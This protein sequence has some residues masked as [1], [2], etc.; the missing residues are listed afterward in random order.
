[1]SEL[2]LTFRVECSKCH[3]PLILSFVQTR[4]ASF[5]PDIWVVPC[6]SCIEDAKKDERLR[7]MEDA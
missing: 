4:N 7:I 2:N 1:M 6:Q 3:D 5:V